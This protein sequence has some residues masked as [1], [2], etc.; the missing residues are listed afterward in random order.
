MACL[1]TLMK[2]YLVNVVLIYVKIRIILMPVTRRKPGKS[3]QKSNHKINGP[4]HCL[5]GSI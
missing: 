4:D 3:D 1:M 5:F 2:E